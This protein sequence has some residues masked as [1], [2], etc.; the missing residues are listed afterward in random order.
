MP[1][2][3]VLGAARHPLAKRSGLL[4]AEASHRRCQIDLVGDPRPALASAWLRQLTGG[5]A[6]R[7][8]PG[9]VNQGD[10]GTSVGREAS[11]RAERVVRNVIRA[12][13]CNCLPSYPAASSLC[14][15]T[16]TFRRAPNACRQLK[17]QPCEKKLPACVNNSALQSKCCKS[18]RRSCRPRMTHLRRAPL[19][20]MINQLGRSN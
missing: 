13:Q 1:P 14:Q 17:R 15:A 2:A 20:T 8:Q 11:L 18:C 19:G 4:V 5:K 3:R 16:R 12:R 6:N 7:P 9:T 10:S